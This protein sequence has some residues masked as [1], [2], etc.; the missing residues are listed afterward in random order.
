MQAVRL[1]AESRFEVDPYRTSCDLRATRFAPSTNPQL[2]PSVPACT[3]CDRRLA[4]GE[5][6]CTACGEPSAGLLGSATT[7]RPTGAVRLV[8]CPHCEH[9]NRLGAPFCAKCGL[10]I[11]SAH[12]PQVACR[13]CGT[14]PTDETARFCPGCG[15]RLRVDAVVPTEPRGVPLVP[16]TPTLSVLDKAGD[17]TQVIPV[18][19]TAGISA[20]GAGV[21]ITGTPDDSRANLTI[22]ADGTHVEVE[23]TK[24][25]SALFVFITRET[26]L[27]DGDLL[28]LGTQVLRVRIVSDVAGGSADAP[29][30]GSVVPAAD[31]VVLEQLMHHGRVRDTLHLWEGRSIL[32]GREEGDWIF[33]YDRTMSARHAVVSV[34]NG[35]ITVKDIGSRNGVA[36]AS[37][38]TLRLGHGQ[39]VSVDGQMLRV[40]LA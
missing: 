22:R 16:S 17:V 30:V 28:L 19:G 25:G 14:L 18:T 21:H 15:T 36:V 9:A 40:D 6:Y 1:V 10:K 5:R 3:A 20:D 26:A 32:I 34:A 11:V 8:R 37:R 35:R 7:T 2:T 27:D 31:V 12:A 13:A 39:R 33:P 4:P 38:Q 29:V 23:A 24:R